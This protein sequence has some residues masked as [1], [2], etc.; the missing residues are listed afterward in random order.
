MQGFNSCLLY[1]S[2]EIMNRFRGVAA[3]RIS[4]APN[5]F[6]KL[7]ERRKKSRKDKLMNKRT[8]MTLVGK[9]LE[10]A[11]LL[12]AAI[13]AAVPCQSLVTDIDADKSFE[14]LSEH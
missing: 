8:T 7:K 3:N 1:F 4:M 2:H 12:Q 13:C 6:Q 10:I 14:N 9:Q 11:R 5:G